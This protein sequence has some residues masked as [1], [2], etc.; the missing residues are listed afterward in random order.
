MGSAWDQQDTH[1][2]IREVWEE[3]FASKAHGILDRNGVEWSSANVVRIGYYAGE[4]PP[5]DWR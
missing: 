5:L 1:Y 3:D 4:P 2:Q